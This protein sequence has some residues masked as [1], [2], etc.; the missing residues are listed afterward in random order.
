MLIYP[1]LMN[2]IIK[3][4][5]N[6]FL[7][8]ISKYLKLI[9]SFDII[10]YMDNSK[11]DLSRDNYLKKEDFY[12]ERRYKSSDCVLFCFLIKG[13]TYSVGNFSF[14]N[15]PLFSMKFVCDFIVF[16]IYYFLV[17][18]IINKVIEIKK[19]KKKLK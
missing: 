10:I 16:L 13:I 17:L 9:I 8:T 6:H 18:F 12:Y 7:Y 5:L 2:F 14:A 19:S 11:N 4:Y 15:A 1:F 3:S